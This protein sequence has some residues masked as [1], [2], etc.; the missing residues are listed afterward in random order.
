MDSMD[1]CMPDFP[2]HHQ[3]PEL[4]LNSWC[5]PTISSSV[6]PFSSYLQ[7]F[8]ASESFLMSH[9]FASA[10]ASVLPM[11]VQ[12]WF[13]LGLT[14][15]ISLLSKGVSR[16]RQNEIRKSTLKNHIQSEII[17][18]L[19]E[20]LT[21]IWEGR[22]SCFSHFVDE[23]AQAQRDWARDWMHT[24]G[25]A[26]ESELSFVYW[27]IIALQCCVSFCCTM[28]WISRMYTYISSPLDLPPRN[29][30]PP[31]EVI[32]EHHLITIRGHPRAPSELLT[33]TSI[34]SH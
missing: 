25:L 14:G 9:F 30:F 21:L 22:P 17:I 18:I 20:H 10:S 8:P 7:S 5:H 27:S 19:L 6:I 31:F 33:T 15:L 26:P 16:V 12:D 1:C 23:K 32:P 24:G 34:A 11:N 2:V 28:T 29:P 3:L 4:C 13:P